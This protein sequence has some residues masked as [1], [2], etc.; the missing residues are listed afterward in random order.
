MSNIPGLHIFFMTVGEKVSLEALQ[1]LV[2]KT[3][4]PYKLTIWFDSC[5]RYIDSDFLNSLKQYTD[6]IIILSKNHGATGALAYALLY[7][8]GENI[9]VVPADCVVQEGYIERFKF[10]LEKIEKVACVGCARIDGYP[11]HKF[12][13]DFMMNSKYFMPDGIQVFPRKA[14]NEIGGIDVN[15]KGMGLENREWHERAIHKGW[16]VV[17]CSGVM[18]EIGSTHDGRSLNPNLND[19]ISESTQE[20][21]KILNS[22]WERE[23]WKKGET[24]NV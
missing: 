6:D 11:E 3:N 9:M 24:V 8:P 14:I 21:L 16:N 18:R 20:Y 19:E 4:Q 17:S 13:F 5:G 12:N 7:L 2:E 23:W 15:F 10:A 1:A 22:K